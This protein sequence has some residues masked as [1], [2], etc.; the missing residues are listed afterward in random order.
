MSRKKRS[1]VIDCAEELDKIAKSKSIFKRK[2]LIINAKN[3]LIDS[4]S[5]IALNCLHGN[6]PLKSCDF[7]RLQKSRD[8]LRFLASKRS[9][10][11][12]RKLILNQINKQR[13]GFLPALLTA[14]LVYLGKEAGGY[15]IDRLIQK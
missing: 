9:I 7:K 10:E 12:R 2:Q 3:C 15:I 5:E 11:D 1:L 8:A 13:G 14:A 6:I 4:I